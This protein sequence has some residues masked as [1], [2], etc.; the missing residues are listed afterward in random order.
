M[1]VT[2]QKNTAII[3]MHT[4]KAKL[5]II[6]INPFVFVPDEILKAIFKQ[7]GKDKGHI[8]IYGKVNGKEYTQTLVKYSGNWRLYINTV[9]LK[10]SPKRIGESIEVSVAFDPR[11]RTIQPHPELV[12]ALKEN[13]EAQIAFGQLPPSRQKEII[14]Y[15]ATL[16]TEESIAKN[17][18][19]AI[20]FLCG[21]NKFVGRDKP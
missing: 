19:K 4:F 16:K 9:M 13:K 10:D 15:I 5:E 11:D 7:A 1:F 18:K 6:G 20:G 3:K 12:K 21:E 8:P 14:R 17:I 2:W